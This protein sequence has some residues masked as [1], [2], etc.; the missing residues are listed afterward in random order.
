VYDNFSKIELGLEADLYVTQSDVYSVKIE[1]SQNLLE[2]IE[3]KVSGGTLEIDLKK[4]KCIKGDHEVKIYVS[5]PSVE[6]VA[7]S[8]SGDVFMLNKIETNKLEIAISGS[9]NVDVDSLDTDHFISS[10]SGSGDLDLRGLDTTLTQ[11]IRISGSGEIIA[12]Q[13]PTLN[14]DISVSGSGKCMVNVVEQLDV[15][16]SGSGEVVY[17][18][19]PVVSQSVSGSGSVGP[20]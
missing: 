15:K 18:G 9:G 10:I 3:T 6:K 4:R 7:V 12:F 19:K 16:I 8:G 13:M 17:R 5:L 1:T 14:S 11:E 2:I 20:E